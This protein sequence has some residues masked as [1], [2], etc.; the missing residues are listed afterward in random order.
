MSYTLF[1]IVVLDGYGK[2]NSEFS[3]F[4]YVWDEVEWEISTRQSKS[5]SIYIP[6][7]HKH[8]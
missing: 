5:I 2:F 8:M 6:K 7:Y 3:V 4:S 1:I